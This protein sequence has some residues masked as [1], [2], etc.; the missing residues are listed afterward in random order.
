MNYKKNK[1]K[2][3][4]DLGNIVCKK[5]KLEYVQDILS[6]VVEKLLINEIKPL[7][8][9]GGHEIA[10]GHYKGIKNA[11]YK[12]KLG[13][14]N[15]DSHLDLRISSNYSTSGSPFYQIFQDNKK[16]FNYQVIGIQSTANT[17]TLFS[18]AKKIGVNIILAED[19]NNKNEKK[20]LK[21]LNLFINNIDII[22]ITF[23]LDVFS[24][25]F[26]PGVSSP[27]AIGIFPN[28][29]IFLL[30]HILNS[31]KVICMDIAELSPKFDENKKTSNLAAHLAWEFLEYI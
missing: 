27:Q 11:Y 22:Y 24:S 6:N 15:F 9:G 2:Y 10:F 18:T 1:S 3:I 31:K 7:L 20:I 26:A 8:F 12:K 5:G 21:C 4:I 13:I 14:I 16:N 23:C 19:I 28:Q 30:R 25:A 29:A 17:K